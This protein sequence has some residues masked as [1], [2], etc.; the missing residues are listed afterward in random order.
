MSAKRKVG[1][2]ISGRGSNLGALIAG[3]DGYEIVL[4][5]SNVAYAAGLQRAADAGIATL[6]IPHNGKTRET[7][8]AELDVALRAAEVEIVCL[9]RKAAQ[10]PSFTAAGLQ[11]HAGA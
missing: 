10:H 5:I 11:G 3:A 9:G 8:D 1:V 2:L 7:F 4:V 6:T